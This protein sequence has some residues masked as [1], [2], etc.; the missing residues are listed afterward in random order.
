MLRC[1]KHEKRDFCFSF[2]VNRGKRMNR[3]AL[4]I[5]MIT[6][7]LVDYIA[8]LYFPRSDSAFKGGIYVLTKDT[9]L[10]ECKYLGNIAP[11]DSKKSKLQN[12]THKNNISYLTDKAIKLKAN[13]VVFDPHQNNDK[14]DTM[15]SG[16]SCPAMQST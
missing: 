1:S 11:D 4:F 13:V 8:I 2:F 14:T 12:S 10:T 3:Y 5:I 6:V 7:V 16:Y 15:G 9:T